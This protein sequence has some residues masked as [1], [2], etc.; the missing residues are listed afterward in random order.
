[1]SLKQFLKLDWRKIILFIVFS[2]SF[3]YLYIYCAVNYCESSLI[4]ALAYPI[5]LIYPLI[6]ALESIN[7]FLFM[8]VNYFIT[9]FIS[10]LY[11]YVLSCLIVWIYD[12]FRKGRKK[13]M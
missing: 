12:K 9:V 8:V 3:V 4:W 7:L 6:L 5:T 13:W 11:W 10:F 2:I 1:M